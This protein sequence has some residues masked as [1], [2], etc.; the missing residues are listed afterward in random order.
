MKHIFEIGRYWL[1]V[2]DLFTRPEKWPV[3]WQQVL[4]EMESMGFGSLVI[5]AI[6]SIFMGA[7]ITIQSAY[8]LV[9]PAVPLSAIGIVARDSIIIEFSPTIIMM[10]LAGKIGSSISGE[11][12][13]MRV[14]EQI[15]ALEIMG[16]N[17]A[18]FLVFPKIFAAIF[19][20]PFVVILSMFM[21]V[22]GGW[23]AG[24]LTGVVP[25]A[26]YLK[27]IQDSFLPFNVFFALVKTVTFAYI[28]TSVSAYHGYFTDGGSLEVGKASTKAVVYSN[29]L[30][31][32][33]DYILT[34]LFLA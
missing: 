17:S 26:D 19:I 9:S 30:I 15:D 28:I 14:T 2:K 11:I 33:F 4:V 32:L 6:N 21:G 10:V 12:G 25:S 5:V 8:N 7:V 3:F 18:S 23:I 24:D 1:F 31:L 22:F 29:I 34:M 16:I 20:L 13:T 27:G